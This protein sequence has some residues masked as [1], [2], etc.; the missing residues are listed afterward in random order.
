MQKNSA[1]QSP[2]LLPASDASLLSAGQLAASSDA[3]PSFETSESGTPM[4]GSGVGTTG[5]AA[6]PPVVSRSL[7]FARF[8]YTRVET[9]QPTRR[10]YEAEAA[11]I[12]AK[13]DHCMGRKV[14][15]DHGLPEPVLSMYRLAMRFYR[16]AQRLPYE[17]KA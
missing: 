3:A 11:A 5:G 14:Y 9:T 16:V 17:A 7:A 2:S 10:H 4:L 12:F 6:S 8:P 1:V 15:S 13:V